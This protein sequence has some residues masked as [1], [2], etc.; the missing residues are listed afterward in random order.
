MVFA[1]DDEPIGYQ[2][3]ILFTLAT[4]VRLGELIAIHKSDF[5]Y[6]DNSVKISN[7]VSETKVKRKLGQTKNKRTRVEF[8]PI[9]LNDLLNKPLEIEV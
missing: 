3:A 5:N 7:A 1:L 9:E 4:G 6:T 8:Y 2:F